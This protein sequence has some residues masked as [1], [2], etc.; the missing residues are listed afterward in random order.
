MMKKPLIASK[1][2]FLQKKIHILIEIIPYIVKILYDICNLTQKKEKCNIR[3]EF[4][5]GIF[6]DS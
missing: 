6:F 2:A 3:S 4:G 1:A 5:E